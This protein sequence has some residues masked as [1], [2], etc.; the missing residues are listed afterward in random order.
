MYLH[1]LL[2]LNMKFE[3]KFSNT[4]IYIEFLEN[5]QVLFIKKNGCFITSGIFLYQWWT[6]F[7]YFFINTIVEIMN[8]NLFS[9]EDKWLTFT[10]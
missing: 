1:L 2:S 3:I 7:S 8:Q 10:R 6:Y 9:N 4:V 5:I